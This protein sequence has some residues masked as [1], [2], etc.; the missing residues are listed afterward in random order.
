MRTPVERSL[1]ADGAFM[2]TRKR[3]P[4]GS[5][6]ALNFSPC[7][8]PPC[9]PEIP[10]VGPDL[11]NCTW[12]PWLLRWSMSAHSSPPAFLIEVQFCSHI[13]QPPNQN[14]SLSFSFRWQGESWGIQVNHGGS[15]T[16]ANDWFRM[17]MWTNFGQRDGGSLQGGS[18]GKVSLLPK[19][20]SGKRRPLLLA[21]KIIMSGLMPGSAAVTL[22][23]WGEPMW[24]QAFSWRW[25]NSEIGNP[26]PQDLA[27]AVGGLMPRA[28]PNSGD[29]QYTIISLFQ[30]AL[31]RIFSLQ[32][33]SYLSFFFF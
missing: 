18:G 16:L 23:P 10:C 9:Q 3:S 17:G 31:V 27:G 15:I 32:P 13:R 19:R 24:S 28:F 8:F 33:K 22:G 29:R 7:V 26:G 12:W 1:P 30:P 11:H 5:F 6:S 25:Q 4:F 2:L 20:Q 14:L 21:L